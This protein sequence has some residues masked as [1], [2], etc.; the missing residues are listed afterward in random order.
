M[1]TKETVIIKDSDLEAIKDFARQ[2][3]KK[4]PSF[5]S[6]STGEIQ[7]FCIVDGLE[8][9]LR[10]KGVDPGYSVQGFIQGGCEPVSED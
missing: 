5:G 3:F 4:R 6:L 9:F 1:D 7:A 10:S 8:S 2:A